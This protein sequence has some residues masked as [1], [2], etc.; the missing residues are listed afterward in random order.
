MWVVVLALSVF[1]SVHHLLLYY[2]LQP[3]S[4][5]LNVRN[6]F[7]FL[8]NLGVS[9]AFA[10]SLIAGPP[11]AAFAAAVGAAALLYLAAAVPLVRKFGPRT[12]RV[13]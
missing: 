10:V 5:E 2:L 12:F 1:F 6:P 3:Y 9:I 8:A 4:A 7:F 11:A 13:K